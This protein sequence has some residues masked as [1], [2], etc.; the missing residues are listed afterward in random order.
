MSSWCKVENGQVVDGPRA[1]TD[2]VPPDS[3]WLRHRLEDKEH[4]INDNFV[5][6]HYEVRGDVVVEVKDYSPKSAE[7]IADEINGLKQTAM[8]EVA[9]ADEKLAD[10]ELGNREEWKAFRAAWLLLTNATEL[11]WGYFMP[12]RPE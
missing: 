6:S 10:P 9:Y 5:G 3:S 4:T 8:R 7:Q 2:D 11:S 1:W 12:G